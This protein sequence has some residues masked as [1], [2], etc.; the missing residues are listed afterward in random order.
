MSA[1]PITYCL[2]HLSDY[3]QFERLCSAVLAG[4]G[5]PAIDPLG[6]TG[7]EGRDAIVRSDS[8]GRTI[9]FAYTVRSDW[10]TKLRSD[11][12]RVRETGHKPDVFVFVCAQVLSAAEKD[13]AVALV[14]QEFGWQLD[15][16]DLERLRVHLAGSQRHL[17]AQHPSIFVPPFFPQR[18]GESIAHSRDVILIDHVNADH[19]LATWLSRR[20]SL[21]GFRTWCQGTAP[22]AGENAD[23]T[24]RTLIACRASR[25]LPIL[26][27]S[28]LSDPLFLER[29]TVAGAAGNDVIVP[30]KA[31]ISPD[32][33]LP[34]RIEKLV[35]ADFSSSW[36]VG[37]QD[38]LK[39]LSSAGV[40]PS[41]DPDRAAQIALGDFLPTQVT[42]AKPEPVFANVFP[43]TIPRS[44]LDISLS[45]ALT[46]TES[47]ELRK[48][49]AFY[50]ANDLTLISF[51]FPPQDSCL[52]DVTGQYC[53][54]SWQ[55]V[56][57]THGHRSEYVA[58]FLARRSLEVACEAKELMY[59][60]DR[61]G[62]H[63]T[64]SGDQEWNQPYTH[65]D[66]QKT[67][68]QLTGGRTKG[69]GERASPFRYQLGPRFRCQQDSEGNWATVI[70]I[71][72]RVTT[73]EGVVFEGK[74]IGRRRKIVSK[75]W[76]NKQWLARL[77]G[78]V[79]ALET[80]DGNVVIG[81]GKRAVVMTTAPM[82]WEC[83]VGLDVSSL[84]EAADIGQE[85][86][87]YRTSNDEDDIEDD[88]L[89]MKPGVIA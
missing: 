31:L 70:R 60:Q 48:R 37:L 4:A 64:R 20:L 56:A 43:M 46:M 88:D 78:V 3:R 59:C 33:A 23:E 61:H 10:R 39:A 8:A 32:W 87:L 49:W 66:G 9:C 11:C 35:A 76:W 40:A 74:E 42:I 13:K 73:L 81:D 89:P 21:A 36:R 77:L 27:T 16:F 67:T 14:R 24:V 53:E 54:F 72:I 30:C 6:G 68:V 26:S 63:F 2:E 29:C 17:I 80:K 34:S 22:L 45:R 44:M 69:F 84:T 86:A 85:I 62:Y 75:S 58:K 15:L 50:Q 41:I 19:A 51:D 55:D 28:S 25:Y 12:T 82:R 71:Y 79:Q 57:F 18:G 1:D 7:D 52:G 5:Y 47:H 38:V 65:V 83:P